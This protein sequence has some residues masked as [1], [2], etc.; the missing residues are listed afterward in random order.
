MLITADSVTV[1]T[2]PYVAS[3]C[4]NKLEPPI[5]RNKDPI[6][7]VVKQYILQNKLLL[8]IGSGTGQH[9]V[10]LAEK[11]SSLDWVTSDVEEN[12][13]GIKEWLKDAKLKNIKGPE[14]LK[15]GSDDFPKKSFFRSKNF[16]NQSPDA[17][18]MPMKKS[19]HL[20]NIFNQKLFFHSKKFFHSKF[21][22]NSANS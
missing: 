13:S 14:T 21:Q 6:Y 12:H 20:K 5:Q 18:E 7:Q 8:E 17:L 10:Y 11:F 15:I 3:S 16:F 1:P 9:A 2:S 19:F 22:S 4:I